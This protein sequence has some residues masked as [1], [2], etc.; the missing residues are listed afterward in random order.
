M[1]TQLLTKYQGHKLQPNQ[2][3]Q[4]QSIV[5]EIVNKS[6]QIFQI[7][8]ELRQGFDSTDSGQIKPDVLKSLA[9]KLGDLNDEIYLAAGRTPKL[10]ITST[11]IS[12]LK[13]LQA[14]TDLMIRIAR[15]VL[16]GNNSLDASLLRSNLKELKTAFSTLIPKRVSKSKAE[17][18]LD[19]RLLNE[20][21]S[22]S[23]AKQETKPS[24]N[25]F[26]DV[27]S[28][29]SLLVINDELSLDSQLKKAN[30]FAESAIKNAPQEAFKVNRIDRAKEALEA[31]LEFLA[32]LPE[33]NK[34]DLSESYINLESK[35]KLLQTKLDSVPKQIISRSKK[36][37]ETKNSV[38]KIQFNEELEQAFSELGA[39]FRVHRSDSVNSS[40]ELANL[41]ANLIKLTDYFLRKP[42][43]DTAKKDVRKTPSSQPIIQKI[44]QSPQVIRDRLNKL[45]QKFMKNLAEVK[46]K[47]RSN[48][49]IQRI[50]LVKQALRKLQYLSQQKPKAQNGNSV[51]KGTRALRQIPGLKLGRLTEN[52]F[53]ALGMALKSDQKTKI[54]KAIKQELTE[55]KKIAATSTVN[56]QIIFTKLH[57]L[58]SEF[59][60]NLLKV[61]T[62]SG[63]D[64]ERRNLLAAALG[65]IHSISA[66]TRTYTDGDQK[67]NL[68]LDSIMKALDS[69]VDMKERFK[70][71]D[72]LKG[73]DAIC[74]RVINKTKI[75]IS[76]LADLRINLKS[77]VA[78]L[79]QSTEKWPGV[80]NKL[81]EKISGLQEIAKKPNL[82]HREASF[83]SYLEQAVF[84]T[85]EISKVDK[86]LAA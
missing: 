50:G 11:N 66:K 68:D 52:L 78:K 69:A 83:L 84:K 43:K 77:L 22:A 16:L 86:L 55:L 8:R 76:L 23:E 33:Q 14:D 73:I 37:E 63:F 4:S 62:S 59:N 24:G 12:T 53:Y 48:Y 29:F 25:F 6:K 5:K 74:A 31:S 58:Y 82:N 80:F 54:E 61:T 79:K 81:I 27:N 13:N 2:S 70:I 45:F 72:L 30:E 36:S 15:K 47:E 34:L 17:P 32:A 9:K 38:I 35:L 10:G 51:S 20:L 19:F 64:I 56:S 39:K 42:K 21:F 18:E 67:K 44:A 60:K 41:R 57:E 46:G 28:I 1:P 40:K 65:R 3:P 71:E 75:D 26:R 49:D 7:L 85:L